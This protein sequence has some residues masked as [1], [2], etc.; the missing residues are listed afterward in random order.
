MEDVILTQLA[1]ATKSTARLLESFAKISPLVCEMRTTTLS[2]HR[3]VN[4][5]S[6]SKFP[7]TKDGV[8]AGTSTF[9]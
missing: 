5:N 6:L 9:V 4:P 7:R 1:L 2:L 3:F 8:E